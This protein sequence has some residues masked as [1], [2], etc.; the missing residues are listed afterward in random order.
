MPDNE[1]ANR[2]QKSETHA[3]TED[4]ATSPASAAKTAPDIASTSGTL[5]GP[6]DRGERTDVLQ[7]TEQRPD[8]FEYAGTPGQGGAGG[9]GD[10][11]AGRA[12]SPPSNFER[13]AADRDIELTKDRPEDDDPRANPGRIGGGPGAGDASSGGGAGAGIPGGGTDMRT[14]GA[15]SGGDPDEDRHRL[16]PD[17]PAPSRAPEPP[18]EAISPPGAVVES[19]ESSYGGPIKIRTTDAGNEGSG[20]T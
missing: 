6:A 5:R 2:A 16:F 14:G 3:A 4:A 17:A 1:Q 18:P 9:R 15:F 11:S 20:R 13:G 7:R 12:D 8:V 19:D 10:P